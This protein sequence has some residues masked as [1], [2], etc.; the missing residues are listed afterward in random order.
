MLS[1][2][3]NSTLAVCLNSQS[4]VVDAEQTENIMRSNELDLKILAIIT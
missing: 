2:T 3:S 1:D 4:P